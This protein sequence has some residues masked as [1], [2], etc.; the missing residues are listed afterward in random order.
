MRE[1]R[2]RLCPIGSVLV[3]VRSGILAHTLPVALID[4]EVTINQDLKAFYSHEP[5]LNEWLALSLR[6]MSTDILGANRKDGTTVQS[7]RY[8]ELQGLKIPVPPPAEQKRIFKKVEQLLASVNTVRERMA[9]L[10]TIL[11][12]FRQGVLAAAGSG[13]LTEDWRAKFQTETMWEEADLPSGWRRLRIEALLPKG[14]IFDGPFG[15]NLKT[16][17]YT[18][19]GVRVIR[20]ENIAQLH[21]NEEKKTYISQRKYETLMKHTVNEN[22]IIFASFI[23]TEVR[24]CV[25]P[26]LKTKAIAKAD[27]FCLRPNPR[28]NRCYLAIQLVSRESYEQLA[29]SVHGATRPRVNTTQLRSL[30]VRVCPRDEQDEIVRRAELL[31]KLA[32]SIDKRIAAANAQAENLTQ[33]ILAKAFRGELVP[34][35]AELARREGRDYEPASALLARIRAVRE[36]NG[37]APKEKLRPRKI[38]RRTRRSFPRS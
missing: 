7:V 30:E 14:G 12:R 4:A 19:S 17:D 26:S 25:L 13:R 28:T 18:D 5:T 2:L 24:A 32:E 1:T 15:S 33:A 38:A 3:V 11:K 9:R 10:A 37:T 20:L 36:S 34:T 35:E 8:G 27:C 31:F 23:D 22:D 6:T 16:D 29:Q 21:F